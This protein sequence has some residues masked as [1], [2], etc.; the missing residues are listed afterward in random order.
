MQV[1]APIGTENVFASPNLVGL[2]ALHE[3][4]YA[5]MCRLVPQGHPRTYGG[6][7][8][9]ADEPALHLSVLERCR[10][11]TT[12]HLTYYFGAPGRP[13]D[14]LVPEPDMHIRVYQDAR[15]AEVL[16]CGG[17]DRVSMLRGYLPRTGSPTARRWRL[18]LMLNRWLRYCLDV[19]HRFPTDVAAPA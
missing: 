11:T 8:R 16:H 14:L 12:Y 4:N 18:N 3:A 17:V 2:M 19:G 6:V 1:R 13:V 7:S 9:V 5:R 10:Y 15:L